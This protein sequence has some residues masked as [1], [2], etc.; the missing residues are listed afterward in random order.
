MEVRAVLHGLQHTLNPPA[1]MNISK[2]ARQHL[3]APSAPVAQT[4]FAT[5]LH[6][7]PSTS[8]KKGSGHATPPAC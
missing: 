6:Q 4:T 8:A 2:D 7:L 5:T 3:R 1:P